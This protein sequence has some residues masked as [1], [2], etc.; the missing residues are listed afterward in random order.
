M[1]KVIRVEEKDGEGSVTVEISDEPPPPPPEG[2]KRSGCLV[3]GDDACIVEDLLVRGFDEHKVPTI[4]FALVDDRKRQDL[5]HEEDIAGI[6]E[7]CREHGITIEVG[8]VFD[9]TDCVRMDRPFRVF[10]NWRM[11]GEGCPWEPDEPFEYAFMIVG[12]TTLCRVCS[13][14]RKPRKDT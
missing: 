6:V 14:E 7:R 10:R 8:E 3:S 1:S 2:W 12:G 4:L 9:E 13:Q 11:I 5:S